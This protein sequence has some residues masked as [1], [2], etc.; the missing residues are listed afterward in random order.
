MAS[1]VKIAPPLTL[2]NPGKIT[3]IVSGGMKVTS[4]DPRVIIVRSG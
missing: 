3:V 4:S 2:P 1:K